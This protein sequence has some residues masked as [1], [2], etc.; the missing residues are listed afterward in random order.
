VTPTPDVAVIGAGIVG[1]ATADALVQAGSAVT[2]YDRAAPGSGQS[3]GVTR[4]FR[5]RHA[6]RPDLT[7]LAV[8]SREAWRAWEERFGCDL[9]GPGGVIS[10]GPDTD[11]R[12][13]ELRVAGV[14]A[15]LA[16]EAEQARLLPPLR[17]FAGPVVVDEDGGP[18][19][20]R[21]IVDALAGGLAERLRTT[22][23]LGVR[24]RAGGGAEV[25]AADGVYRHDVVVVCAGVGTAA[26]ARG[27]DLEL[28]VT[29][30][31]HLR[32]TFPLREPRPA[33]T[34]L[35]CLL[36]GTGEHG[37]GAYG[38]PTPDGRHYGLGLGG[39]EGLPETDDPAAL[40]ALQERTIEYV[41]DAFPG[42]R[43]EPVG[44]RLCP[45]TRL[46]QGDDA[47]AAWRAGDVVVFAGNNLFKHA[48]VLGDLLARS[49]LD[50]AVAETLAA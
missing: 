32:L 7:A 40:S 1:L 47:F 30:H 28:P 35:A 42:L 3:G 23:V 31:H 26:L 4:V 12:L 22:E 10:A 46:P 48:P 14:R 37:P 18:I 5:H 29:V 17:P 16:D 13:R 20:V 43:P 6:G 38:S 25:L 11:G 2:V 9:V 44:A 50:G 24:S 45:I 8:R 39:E 49:A 36:D 27:V 34:T 33:D 15:H 21:A 41:R 19:R